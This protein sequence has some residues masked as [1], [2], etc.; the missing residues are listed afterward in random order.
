[1]A[2]NRL[3]A[4]PVSLPWLLTVLLLNLLHE[5]Q[6]LLVG[7]LQLPATGDE[8]F[9][10]RA[11]FFLPLRNGPGRACCFDPHAHPPVALEHSFRFQPGVGFGDGHHVDFELLGE[12][13]DAGNQA[14]R[15]EPSLR[16]RPTQLVHQLPID[17][18]AGRRMD[19]K[20]IGHRTHPETTA[21][22]ITLPQCITIVMHYG[23][24]S[25]GVPQFFYEP[26]RRVG[27]AHRRFLGGTQAVD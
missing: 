21:G 22:T 20:G 17:R 2:C 16:D 27:C 5:L 1:M 11:Q 15:R 24:K 8:L 13:P 18:H 23:R 4:N 3:F 25:T 10:E 9:G 14:S 6:D 26:V 19:F 12:L 7:Q